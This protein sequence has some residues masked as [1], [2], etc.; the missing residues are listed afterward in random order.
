M[1]RLTCPHCG[2]RDE[3]EFTYGGD[4][5]VTRPDLPFGDPGEAAAFQAYVYTRANPAGWHAEWWHHVQGCRRW[6]KVRRH[7]VTHEIAAV[8]PAD[9]D[10]PPA[11]SGAPAEEGA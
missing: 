1:H 8:V 10:L 7:T 4:A 6:L 11:P 5:G 9:A 3:A 2:P